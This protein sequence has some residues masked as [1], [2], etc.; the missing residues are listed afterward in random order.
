VRGHRP[1]TGNAPPARDEHAR[2]P[3]RAHGYPAHRGDVAQSGDRGWRAPVLYRTLDFHVTETGA[4]Q[5]HLR[6][7]ALGATTTAT[8]GRRSLAWLGHLSDLQLVDDESPTRLTG[9]DNPTIP[10]GLRAQEAYLPRAVSAMSRTFARIERPERPF[11]FSV[12]T[13]DCADSAQENELRWVIALMNGA[14]GLETDSGDDDDPVPGEANDPKDPF[15]PTPFPAPWLYV[16]GNHDVEVVGIT[17]PNDSLRETAIGTRAATGT[18]DYRQWY[19]PSFRG[20]VPADPDRRILERDD[21]VSILREATS[22]GDEGPPGHGYPLTGTVDTTLGANWAFDVVPGLLRVLALDTS[23]PTG[24]SSGLVLQAT[25]DGWLI[26]ELDRAV[27]D[28]VL[29]FL[30]SHHATSSIDVFEGQLG[31]TPV[32]GALTSEELEAIV[33]ARPEVIAWL[34]GHSH[35]NRVRAIEGPDDAHPGYWE[36]MTSAIADYPSQARTIEIVDNADGTLSI[37]ATLIDYDTDDCFERRFRALTQMEWLSRWNDDVSHDPADENVELV[38]TIPPS[39][40]AAV[41]LAST[42]APERIESLTTLAGE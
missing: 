1:G 40:L 24:G 38:H 18:R 26:P 6:L 27:A 28:G 2:R 14:P 10:S 21:I 37:F 41:T 19:A 5:T 3:A 8:T 39:A 33:A 31:S 22:A 32:P 29:V 16:P 35:D 36:I 4:G 9:T 23:D 13:G 11:D 7:T 30:A 34:V 15:D 42:T 20:D 12:I 25:V 17:L